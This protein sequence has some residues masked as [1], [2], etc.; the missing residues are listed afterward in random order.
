MCHDPTYFVDESPLWVH[1]LTGTYF[2]P[3]HKLWKKHKVQ[4]SRDMTPWMLW[5]KTL[6]ESTIWPGLTLSRCI[7]CE[8]NTKSEIHVTWPHECCGWKPFVSLPFD[9]DS[10]CPVNTVHKMWKKNTTFKN[11][12]I[13]P[14]EYCGWKPF[15]SLPFD[16]D[17]LC[18]VN[19]MH[20]IWTKHKV[21]KSRDMT[22]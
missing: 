10:L 11:H 21:Q 14:D 22:P 17:L 1:H 20:K 16:Q 2:V 12:V 4:K 9:Q 8:K 7:N 3:V 19:T 18:S 15:T 6:C 13:W 5:M